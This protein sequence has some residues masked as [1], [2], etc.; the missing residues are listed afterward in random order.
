MH[1]NYFYGLLADTTPTP[2]AAPAA[3][4]GSP[5]QPLSPL[6]QIIG[7]PLIILPVMLVMLYVVMIRPQSQQ[8]KRQ[9]QML[10]ALKSGDKVV[11]AAGIV[12][13]VITV[14]DKTVNS[15]F[16]RH[17][18]G[19]HQ[20]VRHGN[21]RIGGARPNPK[22][23]EKQQQLG[24]FHSR[25]RHHRVV[26]VFEFIRRPRAIWPTNLPAARES[27]T[28]RSRTFS[29]NLP[30]CKRPA[31][32]ANSSNLRAAIGTNDFAEQYFP[33]INAKDQVDPN[34]Y[35]LN[36]LQRDAAGKIKLGLDLQG[37]TSFL[38]GD[39]HERAGKQD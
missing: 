24:P 12:G 36:R 10:A 1:L 35:I 26:A 5:G 34:T 6:Q 28:R 15:A 7:N 37:G 39:G 31:P 33:F 38:V 21:S 3:P 9:A 25:H 8:R 17:E 13:M 32:T 23:H 19:S 16:R 14:K 11:T 29:R 20:G 22:S 18:N 30:R 4:A 2:A 27:P